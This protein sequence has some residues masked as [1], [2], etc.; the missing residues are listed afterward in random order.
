[1][2]QSRQ[3]LL[4]R[5][6]KSV[7]EMV[8]IG[9][10]VSTT[11]PQQMGR[12]KVVC[13]K[14]GDRFDQEIA[15]LPWTSYASPFAGDVAVGS[16]GPGIQET[17]G[18]VAYGFWAIPKVGAQ[19]VVMCVDGDPMYRIY[20]AS[21]YGTLS[22]HTLPH[23]R[24]K[25]DGHPVI[26]PSGSTPYG[27]M[28]SAEKPIEPLASNLKKAFGRSTQNH[29]WQT[30]GADYQVAGIGP[31]HV[32]YTESSAPDDFQSPDTFTDWKSTQGYGVSRHDATEFESKVVALTSPGFHSISMDDR[33]EN[34]RVR[35]RTTSGHQVLLD[36]TNERIYI[37]TAQGNNWVEMDQ[38]G[39]VDI[40][41][42]N[43]VSIR[44]VKDI[45]L[46]SDESIR[47][48]AKKGIHAYSG[49]DIR[50]QSVGDTNVKVGS[51]LRIGVGDDVFVAAGSDINLNAAATLSATS[52]STM[53]L[54]S[55]ADTRIT[56]AQ[57]INMNAGGDYLVTSAQVHHNG[58][59]ASQAASAQLPNEQPA[60][61]TNKVPAHE[62]YART[63]TKTDY[64]HEPE[65]SYKD[66]LVNRFERG[67]MIIRGLFW[68]R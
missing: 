6:T 27:P 31:Q 11:D 62:P 35:M 9:T 24:Y 57:T 34:C 60:M 68:R 12:L 18:S 50:L 61:W 45:N 37:S 15:D 42:A 53:N 63:M 51:S 1:M 54:R 38:D 47:L 40:F 55:A 8:T 4:S 52:S 19:V 33:I 16:R 7:T 58:P 49:T 13:P 48:H 21:I 65:L 39:N 32:D 67:R 25:Y 30:R 64:T 29:E 36:D 28:S 66:K 5:P 17:S 44:S 3:K 22:P 14:W 20:V 10:V 46:T 59:T 23:G 56:A 43:K 2:Y 26:E 41:S